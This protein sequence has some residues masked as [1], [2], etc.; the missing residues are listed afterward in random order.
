[1]PTT[2][3]RKAPIVST[4]TIG[5]TALEAIK[6]FDLVP[7]MVK[8]FEPYEK[9]DVGEFK[10]GLIVGSSGSGKSTLLK[11]FGT[12]DDVVWDDRCIAD[13][14]EVSEVASKLYAAGLNSVPSWLLRYDELSTGQKF[15]ADLARRLKTD[16]II[17]EFSSVVD[18]SV[19][20]SASISVAR[21]IR[22]NDL[23]GVIFATCHR[24]VTRWLAPDWII[25]TDSGELFFDEHSPITWH[26][27]YILGPPDGELVVR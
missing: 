7:E 9:P 13:H 20:I 23:N 4:A 10:M 16:S 15:R 3:T 2:L 21:H 17:D 6:P 14:F 11:E 25:D 8:S 1:M 5:E 19:A 18:R 24:D 22:N 12:A 26:K 27:K